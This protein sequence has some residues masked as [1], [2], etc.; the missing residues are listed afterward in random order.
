[1]ESAAALQSY[2]LLVQGQ[3]DIFLKASIPTCVPPCLELY[4]IEWMHPAIFVSVL[5]CRG[6]Q[7]P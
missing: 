4:L 5:Y 7:D 3:P 6:S 1:M 2:A